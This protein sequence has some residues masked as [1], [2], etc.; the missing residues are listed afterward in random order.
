MNLFEEYLRNNKIYNEASFAEGSIDKVINNFLKVIGKRAKLKFKG[1]SVPYSTQFKN[2]YGTFEGVKFMTSDYNK[3]IRINWKKGKSTEI[4]NID[5]WLSP[6]SKP[7]KNLDCKNLNIVQI[8]DMISTVL[9]GKAFYNE[10]IYLEAQFTKSQ[11]KELFDTIIKEK[12]IKVNGSDFKPAKILTIVNEY[13]KKKGYD[14]FSFAMAYDYVNNYKNGVYKFGENPASLNSVLRP[15]VKEAIEVDSEAD[16]VWKKLKEEGIEGKL[17]GEATFKK[18][19]EYTKLLIKGKS[20]KKLLIIAGDPGLGKSVE[21]KKELNEKIGIG[22]WVKFS[23]SISAF[24][25]YQELYKNNGKIILLDDIDDIYKDKT[26]VNVLKAATESNDERWVDW[27]T[28]ALKGEDESDEMIDDEEFEDDGMNDDNGEN[29]KGKEKKKKKDPNAVPRKFLYTGRIISLTNLYYR[30]L[31]GSLLSRA[32]KVEV[33][34]TPEQAL[35]RIK[36]KLKEF[37]PN[38]PMKIKERAL[39][40]LQDVSPILEKIDFRKVSSVLEDFMIEGISDKEAR[41]W[42]I[43]GL[44]GDAGSAGKRQ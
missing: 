12:G 26:A 10:S 42:A 25:L 2:K 14:Q 19:V 9:G 31:P 5:I 37:E 30:D 36:S 39:K 21:V 40:F 34:F 38:V 33:D 29:K 27:N 35:D 17:T 32:L 7:D 8:V 3:A 23:G 15:G 16:K 41:Q 6:K 44:A 1:P 4:D 28:R 13:A 11:R 22:N 43:V 18:I 20:S 24:S